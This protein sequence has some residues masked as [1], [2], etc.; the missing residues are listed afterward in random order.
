MVLGNSV[1][2]KKKARIKVR[3]SCV[4]MG[5][6]DERGIL[7]EGEIFVRIQRQSFAIEEMT[8]EFVNEQGDKKA[9][10]EQLLGTATKFPIETLSGHVM[11][12]KNPC[13]H[14]G[15]IRLLKTVD[16]KDPRFEEMRDFVNVIV[17]SQKGY[18]P[19]PNKMSGGDLDGDCFM[20]MWDKEV[21]KYL[22][23]DMIKAPA[24]YKKYNDDSQL[25]SDKIEDHIRRYFEKDNLGHLANL[26]LALCD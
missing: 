5:I 4:L 10:Y 3:D 8:E 17:F 24:V 19:D 26:H 21:L 14:P 6:I 15:D 22:T 11:V 23:P 2:L 16:E 9:E 7:E 1:N 25:K 18:R 12:T 13:S 20:V